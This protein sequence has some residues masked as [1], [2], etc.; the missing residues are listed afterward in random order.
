MMQA[1]LI[2]FLVT[3]ALIAA[4]FGETQWI[5]E[6]F[7]HFMLQYFFLSVLLLAFFAFKKQKRSAYMA[8]ALTVVTS[9][10]LTNSVIQR[11]PT[12]KVP[13]PSHQVRIFEFNTQ[14]NVK[15][16]TNWLPTHGGNY[17]LIV[18]LETGPDFAPLMEKLKG[19]FPY[20]VS[21]LDD[22]MF[23]LVVLSRWEFTHSEEFKAEAGVYPQYALTVKAPTGDEFLLYALHVPPP[24]SP[25]MAE[26]HEV[27]VG[28][29]IERLQQKIHPALVVGD[30]NMTQYAKHYAKL[31]RLTGLRDSAGLSPWQHSWPALTVNLFSPLGIRIDHCL[32][33]TTFALVERERLTDLNSDHLPARCV[34]QIEK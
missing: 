19:E 26:A 21:H 1:K 34:F 32:V 30:L 12:V 5:A 18:L 17:D 10:L 13:R 29:L 2:L 8:L 28:E 23:G 6:L 16:L 20:Q 22:S 7:S 33:S 14:M 25:Q 11:A 9:Y 31:L 3:A 15:T 27:I 24:F 4:Q